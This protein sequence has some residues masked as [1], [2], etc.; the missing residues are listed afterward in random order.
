MVRLKPCD[1]ESVKSFYWDLID[2]MRDRRD[3][4][5]WIKGVYPSE[6]MLRAALEKGELCALVENG[7][8]LAAVILNSSCNE[9]YAGVPWRLSASM[10]ETLIPH[11]FAV[12]PDLQGKGLGR[13][14]LSEMEE[15]GRKAGKK[16]MRLDVLGRNRAAIGLYRSAGFSEIERKNLYYDDTG[17]TEFVLFE[18]EL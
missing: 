17:W 4:V 10:E 13:A 14:L 2:V 12:R 8:Y 1:F 7:E 16:A 3:S 18:K 11:A 5:G 15:L 9:D 6:A